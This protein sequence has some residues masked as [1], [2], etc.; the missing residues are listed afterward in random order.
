[1]VPN[2][3]IGRRAVLRLSAFSAV[4]VV[5]AACGAA[6]ET[7]ASSPAS[8]A[9]ASSAKP[10]APAGSTA[11]AASASAA[12]ATASG[13]SASGAAAQPRMGGT[14][15]AGM[16]LDLPSLEVHSLSQQAYENL[17]MVYDRLITFDEQLKPVPQLAESW[18]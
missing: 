8:Q 13:A 2:F 3:V 16:A 5:L 4:G 1:M 15:R 7:P 6:A 14:L 17:W 9:A 18:D 10:A 11:P 12:P